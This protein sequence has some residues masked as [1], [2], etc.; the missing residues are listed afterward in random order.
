MFSSKDAC[1]L[2]L[3][4]MS[5]SRTDRDGAGLGRLWSSLGWQLLTPLERY[6]N[7]SSSKS[8]RSPP[9]SSPHGPG[10]DRLLR[11]RL[12]HEQRA[13]HHHVRA[14]PLQW[15]GWPCCEGLFRNKVHGFMN[16]CFVG[17]KVPFKGTFSNF[18]FLL[19]VPALFSL[20]HLWYAVLPKTS[21]SVCPQNAGLPNGNTPHQ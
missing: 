4:F 3:I 7:Q 18:A 11:R 13:A 16:H 17:I 12:F 2:F 10:G 19:V 9:T 14:L 6:L 1:L 8:I 21:R 15:L 20:N 5:A